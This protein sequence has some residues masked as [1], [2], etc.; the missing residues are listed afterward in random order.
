ML[1]SHNIPTPVLQL[2]FLIIDGVSGDL[3]ISNLF[4]VRRKMR[5]VSGNLGQARTAQRGFSRWVAGY[6]R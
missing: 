1:F 6:D 4:H 5:C 3:K 2:A